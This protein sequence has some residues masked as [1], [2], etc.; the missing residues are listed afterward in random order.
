MISNQLPLLENP[1]T[2]FKQAPLPLPFNFLEKCNCSQPCNCLYNCSL[3]ALPTIYTG[4]HTIAYVSTHSIALPT[5]IAL[6][7]GTNAHSIIHIICIFHH[8]HHLHSTTCT[9]NIFYMSHHQY[10]CTL[11]TRQLAVQL[12][13]SNTTHMPACYHWLC[14]A[15]LNC[16]SNNGAKLIPITVNLIRTFSKGWQ[17]TVARRARGP[18]QS[19]VVV[20]NL[21]LKLPRGH[22]LFLVSPWTFATFPLN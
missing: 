22:M 16:M 12:P 14:I 8:T 7:L 9:T 18:C 21:F 2:T 11:V 15:F 1:S 3:L 19:E 13:F 5:L 17:T 20:L 4:Y 10:D 6:L